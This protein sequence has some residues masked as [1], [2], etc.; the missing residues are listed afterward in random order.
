M[1]NIK[2]DLKLDK[3]EFRL[4]TGINSVMSPVAVTCE[5]VN[6]IQSNVKFLISERKSACEEYLQIKLSVE[7]QV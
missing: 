6:G 1:I 5:R 4:W 7:E 2:K 3:Y